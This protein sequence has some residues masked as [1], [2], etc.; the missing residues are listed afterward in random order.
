MVHVGCNVFA[1]RTLR[2]ED[3]VVKMQSWSWEHKDLPIL[4]SFKCDFPEEHK[5]D[6]RKSFAYWDEKVD[7][8]MFFEHFECLEDEINWVDKKMITV[9][10]KNEHNPNNP[11]S[12]GTAYRDVDPNDYSTIRS[13]KIRF[14]MPWLLSSGKSKQNVARHEVGHAVGLHHIKY[15][16][17]I[18]YKHTRV[19]NS[20]DVEHH[21]FKRLYGTK[22][23]T[24]SETK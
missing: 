22:T 18:M 17:C 13:V 5:D 8:D 23:I 14:W 9:T 24:E 21:E 11:K 2:Y 19:F 1:R 4:W 6:V 10:W 16:D 3:S 7:T 20:C 15:T 12:W